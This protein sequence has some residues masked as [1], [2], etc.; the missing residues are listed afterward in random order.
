M[1][2]VINH[3]GELPESEFLF[4]KFNSGRSVYEVIRIIDG[5]AL[6][7]EDHFKQLLISMKNNGI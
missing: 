6:F 4:D 7:L 3:A 1:K 5:I 2:K